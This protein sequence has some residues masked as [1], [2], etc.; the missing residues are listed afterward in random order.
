M[1]EGSAAVLLDR[2][3]GPLGDSAEP[4]RPQARGAESRDQDPLPH[5]LKG[6]L[7]QPDTALSQRR[8][9]VGSPGRDRLQGG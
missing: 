1:R 8:F 3:L 9:A 2:A 5:F 6:G 7:A 4:S